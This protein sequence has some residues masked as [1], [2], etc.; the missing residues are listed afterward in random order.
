MTDQQIAFSEAIP[1]SL[2]V[3]GPRSSN[4]FTTT[5]YM[6]PQAT[7]VVGT[8]TTTTRTPSTPAFDIENRALAALPP[9]GRWKYLARNNKPELIVSILAMFGGIYMVVAA[10]SHFGSVFEQWFTLAASAQVSSTTKSDGGYSSG[11]LFQ[12]YVGGLM[13]I[14]LLCSWAMTMMAT[15]DTKIAFGKDTIKMILGFVVGFL[16]GTGGSKAR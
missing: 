9:L 6:V 13:G 11:E 5:I 3:D 7:S 2:F 10:L 8:A 1:H 12:W 15:T 14:S 16:S 4:S